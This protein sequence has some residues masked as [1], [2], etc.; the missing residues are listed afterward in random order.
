MEWPEVVILLVTFKR[1]EYALRTVRGLVTHL[2]YPNLVWHIADDGSGEEHQQ[3]IIAA[4]GDQPWQLSDARQQGGAGY[5]RNVG[6][7]H[8]F[9]RTPYVLHIEDDW[10]LTEPL[11]LR[12]PVQVLMEHQDVGM[13]RMGYIEAGHVARS[14]PYCGRIWWELDK[15]SGHTHIFAGHPHVLHRRLHEA[16]GWYP[17][18]ILPGPTELGFA[19]RVRERDGPKVLYMLWRPWGLF[20]HIGTVKAEELL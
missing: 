15:E 16:Y 1:T 5:N 7:R 6:L 20:G 17:E 4:I 13:V 19:D 3:A 12:I 10:E 2:Y 9:D 8:A 18:G 11:D 14:V